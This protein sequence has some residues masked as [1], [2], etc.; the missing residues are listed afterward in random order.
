MPWKLVLL[1][2][3]DFSSRRHTHVGLRLPPRHP[4]WAEVKNIIYGALDHI[5]DTNEQ[6]WQAHSVLVST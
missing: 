3:N 2:V 4:L 1:D 6:N 5:P